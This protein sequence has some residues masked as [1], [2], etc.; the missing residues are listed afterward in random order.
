VNLVGVEVGAI[1]ARGLR[2]VVKGGEET[3]SG[4]IRRAG[5]ALYT[6]PSLSTPTI[7]LPLA[8]GGEGGFIT[9]IDGSS[10][11]QFSGWSFGV[12]S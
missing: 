3:S 1:N 4:D 9:T 11:P 12:L 5:R 2:A 7:K 8:D 10:T 6:S